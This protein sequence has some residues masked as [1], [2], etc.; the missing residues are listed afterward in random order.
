[1]KPRLLSLLLRLLA[2]TWR[3]SI[4]G[5]K[6]TEPC[7][8][9]FWH[10]EMLPVWHVFRTCNAAGLTSSSSD[11]DL[12]AQLLRDWNYTVIRG[13]SSQGGREALSA[14]VGAAAK[15]VVLV[16]PDGP[17]GPRH[18][19]K[20]GAI[21]A[22]Q[23]ARVPLVLCRVRIRRA[24]VLQKS[25]DRFRIPHPFTAIKIVFG[26]PVVIPVTAQREHIDRIVQ[27]TTKHLD[28][29]GGDL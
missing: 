5:S 3:V 1:M 9:A 27:L 28:A 22:A 7:V 15:H 12:L 25:W 20:P 29:L 21:I 18:I 4:H 26:E 17:R 13:S 2:A 6:P 8:V 24:T 14:M 10:D 16:T 11:G 23:R 19:C